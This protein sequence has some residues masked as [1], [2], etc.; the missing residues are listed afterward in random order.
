MLK[1]LNEL[2]MKMCASDNDEIGIEVDGYL[3]FYEDHGNEDVINKIYRHFGT[4]KEIIFY[5]M[6]WAHQSRI[7]ELMDL[8]QE[9][10]LYGCDIEKI[11]KLMKIISKYLVKW[12]SCTE[13]EAIKQVKSMKISYLSIA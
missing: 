10:V 7:K 8:Y 12:S 4:D 2:M 3:Y 6:K 9:N 5:S 13:E 11:K 1:N